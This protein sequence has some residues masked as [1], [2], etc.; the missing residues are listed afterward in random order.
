MNTELKLE[1][2]GISKH[3]GGVCALD[4]VNLNVRQ[5]EVHCLVGENGSGKSTLIKIISGV[6][7]PDSGGAIRFDGETQTS[8]TPKTSV[9]AGVQVIYQDHAL[10]HHLTVAENIAFGES[11]VRRTRFANKVRNRAIAVDILNKVGVD[12]NPDKL[13]EELSVS[14]RQIVAICRAIVA[15]GRFLIMDEPTASL[16]S[17]EVAALFRIVEDLRS[18]GVSI[19]FVSHRLSEVREIAERV[20]VLRDGKMLGT[21]PAADL[22]DEDIATMMTGQNFDYL[23]RIAQHKGA[24][25]FRA[26]TLGRSGEFEDV[27]FSV[28]AGEVV[29]I[30]GTLG[31]GR[32]ELA[33]TIYGITQ[34]DHGQMWLDGQPYAPRDIRAAIDVGVCY[35][36][37][38]RLTLGLVMPQ[39]I[40]ENISISVLDRHRNGIGMLNLNRLNELTQHLVQRLRIKVSDTNLPVSTLSGGNQQ[41]VALA[42]LISTEPRL[43]ILDSPTVGVDIAAKDA[44]YRIVHELSEAGMAVIMIS[45]EEDEVLY[46]AHR[47]ITMANG[48]FGEEFEPAKTNAQEIRSAIHG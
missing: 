30:V 14:S 16:T 41:R 10:F 8:V 35:L 44:I 4:D 3:F 5:G 24:E 40:G 21:H 19:L 33:Q 38:D 23:P 20:S 7:R 42:R 46:H 32:T 48:R 18:D 13:V 37:E 25:V 6:T 2:T 34:A 26:D 12:L 9:A 17:H 39:S 43:M 29:G 1:L 45:D 27:S 28:C 36:P 15:G 11:L 47:I 31:A 22:R